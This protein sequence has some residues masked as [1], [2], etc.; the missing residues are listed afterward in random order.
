M[1][2]KIK[3]FFQKAKERNIETRK[4]NHFRSINERFYLSEYNGKIYIICNNTAIYEAQ[5]DEQASQLVEKLEKIRKT[6]YVFSCINN[7]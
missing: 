1:F 6:A 7:D 3:Q 4:Q 5:K 2:K